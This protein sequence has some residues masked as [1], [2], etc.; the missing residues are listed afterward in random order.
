MNKSRPAKIRAPRHNGDYVVSPITNL[1]SF[2]AQN[3]SVFK[4]VDGQPIF[5]LDSD[6][7][8]RLRKEARQQLMAAATDYVKCYAPDALQSLTTSSQDGPLILTGHQPEFFH[9]GVWFKNFLVHKLAGRCEGVGINIIIDNDTCS[10]SSVVVP[11]GTLE[12]PQRHAIAFDGNEPNETN[13]QQAIPFELAEWKD[14]LTTSKFR[15]QAVSALSS[16][17]SEP[18]V[19]DQV[20]EDL[21]TIQ[22]ECLN[23]GKTI[24]RTR[25]LYELEHKIENLDVPLSH[26][27]RQN[28]FGH[29][30]LDI[31][32]HAEQFQRLYNESLLEFRVQN[33]VRSQSHPVPEL[34]TS[35]DW[36][37]LPFWIWTQQSPWRGP[38][39]I[40]RLDDRFELTDLDQIHCEIAANEAFFE[41]LNAL[42][43]DGVAIRPRALMT[44]MF[45]RVFLADVFVHGIG[46]AKYDELT[47]R[48]IQG[49]YGVS[50]PQFI[51]AT[52]THLLPLGVTP[53]D[54]GEV[55]VRKQEIRSLLFHPENYF[56]GSQTDA[57]ASKWMDKKKELLATIPSRGA[58][59]AWH[60]SLE[61]TN[62]AMQSFI[63]SRIKDCQNHLDDLTRLRQKTNLLTSREFSFLLHPQDLPNVLNRISEEAADKFI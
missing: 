13:E 15:D 58:K 33:K 51:T 1:S 44:T 20:W 63:R 32:T 36:T 40:R 42:S 26:L 19:V 31:F 6:Q 30:L 39:Y 34:V 9:P 46:G 55:A 37:E 60:K 43:D 21:L 25:H 2:I 23:V 18:I 54:E 16:L 8:L 29:F 35:E 17:M 57:T 41:D 48:I 38:L 49:F 22:S 4:D 11:S 62:E 28:T 3:R 7:I 52:S 27:C 24:A 12:N 14:P 59:K 61:E 47:D 10:S 5:N 53:F 56:S 50:P 45:T